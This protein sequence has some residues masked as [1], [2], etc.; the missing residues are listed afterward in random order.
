MQLCR[1]KQKQY[2]TTWL[3]ARVITEIH[4]HS[5]VSYIP[6]APKPKA[7]CFFNMS[8][9]E[10]VHIVILWCDNK[11]EPIGAEL[12]RCVVLGSYVICCYRW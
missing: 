1:H 12:N 10:T 6:A 3:Q 8:D 7:T 4:G 5:T 2:R 9:S 11:K